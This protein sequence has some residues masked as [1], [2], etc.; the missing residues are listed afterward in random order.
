MAVSGSNRYY[1]LK[2]SCLESLLL[3]RL[4]LGLLT[5][6]KTE[7]SAGRAPAKTVLMES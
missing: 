4:T 6:G 1:E 5:V 7:K 2:K 3:L